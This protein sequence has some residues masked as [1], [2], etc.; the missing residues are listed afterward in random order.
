MGDSGVDMVTPIPEDTDEEPPPSHT[1]ITLFLH[2]YEDDDKRKRERES[3]RNQFCGLQAPLLLFFWNLR[4]IRVTFY[5]KHRTKE[6]G[7]VFTRQN[8]KELNRVV[9]LTTSSVNDISAVR[10]HRI[11][12]V[13]RHMV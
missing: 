5:D 11:Y 4:T 8:S 1:R 3:I 2:E 10:Q 6:W 9:L 13:T 12:Q 7:K